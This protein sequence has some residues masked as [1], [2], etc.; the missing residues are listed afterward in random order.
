MVYLDNHTT[1]S[2][3]GPALDRLRSEN[4]PSLDNQT[5]ILYDFV[6]AEIADRFVFTSSGAEAINQ[7][8]WTV[9][10]ELA[11]KEGKCHFITSAFEDA[12]MTQSLKRLE[13]LGCFVKIV[14]FTR[15]GQID[16]VRLAELISP[17]TALISISLA[18]GLTGVVQPVEEIAKLAKE[19]NVLLHV[20]ATYALGKIATPFHGLDYL[21]FA[22]D[23]LHSVKGSGGLFAKA[24]RPLLPFILGGEEQGGLRGGSL[25][26]PSFLALTAAVNQATLFLDTMNLEVARLRDRFE[27]GVVREIPTAKVLFQDALRLP[28]VS[29]ICFPRAHQE[30]MLFLLQRK[31]FLA[32]IGG[33]YMPQLS[34]LLMASG[35]DEQLAQTAVSFSLSRYTTQAEIDKAIALL[36][37]A[38]RQL[39]ALSQDLFS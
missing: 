29:V 20:D 25:D 24:G 14:P 26:T 33:S 15:E 18:Q 34:R 1:T 6:G 9:F 10:L 27:E 39:Y 32:S 36:S 2:P 8:H 13:E 21:T 37:D 17:R 35:L 16:F 30:A 5:Q 4:V 28:N 19:K 23:R 38:V 3:C 11:R 22:G 12:P 31:N 7:V